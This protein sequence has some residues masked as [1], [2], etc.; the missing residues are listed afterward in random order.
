MYTIIFIAICIFIVLIICIIVVSI[1]Y[2]NYLSSLQ[3]E[4]SLALFIDTSDGDGLINIEELEHIVQGYNTVE[5][6][7][8]IKY[9]LKSGC[10]IRETFD[11]KTKCEYRF[12]TIKEL[13]K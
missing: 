1:K 9:F 10:Q 4:T 13:L 5:K 8:E 3:N 12:Q 7:F 2:F 6:E 11:T